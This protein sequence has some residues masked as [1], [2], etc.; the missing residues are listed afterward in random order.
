MGQFSVGIN[1]YEGFFAI[2]E[3]NQLAFCVTFKDGNLPSV[4]QEVAGL[5][6]LQLDNNHS[7]KIRL[8]SGNTIEQ[9]FKWVTGLNYRPPRNDNGMR[10][11]LGRNLVH[12]AIAQKNSPYKSTYKQKS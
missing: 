1:T 3:A 4:W 9:E 7:E 5:T 8:P 6:P 2:C 10:L 12:K 11:K